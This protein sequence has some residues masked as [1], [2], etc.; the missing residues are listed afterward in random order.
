MKAFKIRMFVSAVGAAV[1][2]LTSFAQD[3]NQA[4]FAKYGADAAEREKNYKA[5]SFFNE[6]YNAKNYDQASFHL[7]Q[8][9]TDL[10][11]VHQNLYIRGAAMYKKLIAT[12]KEADQRN[13]YIDSLMILH[14]YRIAN[15]GDDATRG[16]DYILTEKIKD[17]LNFRANNP[18]VVMEEVDGIL[19]EVGSNVNL[20]I[21]PVYFQYLTQL[22]KNDMI[23]TEVL[24]TAYDKL[25]AIADGSSDAAKDE[26]KTA[27][28]QL[29]TSTDA[30]SCDNLES[31]FKP[32]F[33]ANPDDAALVAKI[34]TLLAKA[35]CSTEFQLAIAEKYY[36]MEP[37]A[38]AAASLA[39]GFDKKGDLEKALKY[40]NEAIEKETD[41]KN[42]ASFALSAAGATLVAERYSE[43][44]KYARQAISIDSES[45]LGYFFLA[46]AQSG[47]LPNCG[48]F[49]KK[50]AYWIIVDNLTKARTYLEGDQQEQ[51]SKL[52]SVY[53]QYFPSTE[54]VFFNDLNKGDAYTVNCG[55]VSGRTTVRPR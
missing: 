8:L 3:Y 7:K 41:N 18:E 12:T 46:Q 14:D 32:Q 35:E 5:Y 9:L 23:E 42:K 16:T 20:P 1:L 13:I 38:S 4:A 51:A 34:A 25:T 49:E 21:L 6:E 17:N 27:I 55:G 22:Y 36:E 43:S 48:D 19:E 53:S 28:E 50:A 26:T 44:V 29:F 54:D 39:F 24:L 45:G 37:S 11:N 15:F 31:I 40:Y 33:E 30:A 52:I 2:S 10:P 47:S